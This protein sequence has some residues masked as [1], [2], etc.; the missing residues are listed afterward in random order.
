MS[1]TITTGFG[2]LVALGVGAGDV[3]TLVTIG[4]KVGNFLTAASGDQDLLKALDEDEANILKRRGVL[5]EVRFNQIW[6]ERMTLLANGQATTFDGPLVQQTL[7]QLP[8]LTACMVSII[9]VLDAY[10]EVGTVKAIFK[11]LLL[12]L[13]RSSENGEELLASELNSRLNAWRSAACVRE[14]HFKCRQLR[15]E[16][17]ALQ[18]IQDGVMPIGEARE[19]TRFLYWLLAEN[20]SLFTT[21]SSDVAGIAHCLSRVGFDILSVSGIIDEPLET[22]CRVHFDL[23]SSIS[24]QTQNNYSLEGLGSFRQP[25]TVVPISNPEEAISAFPIEPEIGNWCRQAW[26][27]GRDC[28]KYV[29]LQVSAATRN[30]I[31]QKD[32]IYKISDLGTAPDRVRSEIQELARLGTFIPNREVCVALENVFSRESQDILSFLITQ[33][34]NTPSR[35]IVIA[36]G[37]PVRIDGSSSISNSDFNDKRK[38]DAFTAYQSF[39]MGYYYGIFL[40][41]SVIDTSSLQLNTVD[42]AWSFRSVTLLKKMKAYATTAASQDYYIS[43][44]KLL[45]ILASLLFSYTVNIGF[46]GA[47]QYGLGIIERRAVFANSLLSPCLT[48]QDIGKFKLIDVDA[49]GIPK[50]MYGIIRPGYCFPFQPH[51]DNTTI[52]RR[53]IARGPPEDFTKHIEADW[54]GDAQRMT[55]CIRYKGRRLAT[56]NPCTADQVFIYTYVEPVDNP[57]EAVIE[58]AME[59]TV[60]DLLGGRAIVS[61]NPD[62]RVVVVQARRAPCMRWAYCGMGSDPDC[63]RMASNCLITAFEKIPIEVDGRLVRN[64]AVIAGDGV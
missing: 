3:A 5:D 33:V 58:Q 31:Y 51:F 15:R 8:R 18:R 64:K 47:G 16:L 34:G 14:I 60:E 7:G 46:A 53:I 39:V 21:S 10:C 56:V 55:I 2:S 54:D 40:S 19:T 52:P 12:E 63:V 62:C 59:C 29:R 48:P 49:S 20:S 24:F 9:A 26:K 4:R 23:N 36:R 61:G 37:G 6:G 22:P 17:I 13:L 57:Q 50:D 42:G 1:I 41:N 30:E 32:V 45:E 35:T 27:S 43:R 28:A 38:I 25:R 44:E 11:Q